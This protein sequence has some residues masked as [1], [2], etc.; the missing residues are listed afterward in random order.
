MALAACW[1]RAD[2]TDECHTDE[3]ALLIALILSVLVCAATGYLGARATGRI[4]TG[5]GAGMVACLIGTFGFVALSVAA[6][7]PDLSP[8]R[9]DPSG[10]RIELAL[11]HAIGFSLLVAIGAL[12]CVPIG[13]AVGRWR[14]AR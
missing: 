8:V 12:A 3:Q 1:F 6:A 5:F 11:V 4:S 10:D 9:F 7:A 13:A 14:A 2:Q